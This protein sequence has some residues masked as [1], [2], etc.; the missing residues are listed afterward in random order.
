VASPSREDVK[1]V[2]TS[3]PPRVFVE[4]N[5]GKPDKLTLALC[6]IHMKPIGGQRRK[7]I[8]PEVR[9]LT[10]YLAVQI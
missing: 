6:Q 5:A 4:Q 1:V 9:S 8:S 3:S 10:R 7:T 2:E